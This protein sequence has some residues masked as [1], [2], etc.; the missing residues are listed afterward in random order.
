MKII[1]M[2]RLK[3]GISTITF[4]LILLS[5]SCQNPNSGGERTVNKT[6]EISPKP[7]ETVETKIETPKFIDVPNLANKSSGEFDKIYGKPIEI[8]EIKDNPAM[9]PGEYRLYKIEGHPKG[10]SVR[11]YKDQAKR[12]NLL[13]GKPE[14]SSKD[15]ISGIFKINV[16][17]IQP[18]KRSEPL[19]EKWKG[20][21][22]GINFVTVYAKRE[23]LNGDFTMVHAEVGK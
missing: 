18:D 10:L 15:A 22:N 8:T 6:A 5:L 3:I 13:L 12:F 4:V 16:G 19:S 23:K 14:K 11:F 1:K 7:A 2:E 21:F 9:M 17:E 20:R